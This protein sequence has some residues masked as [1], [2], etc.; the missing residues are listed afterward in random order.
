MAVPQDNGVVWDNGLA[1]YS[2]VVI[3]AATTNRHSPANG[4]SHKF[5]GFQF[6]DTAQG[7]AFR[8]GWIEIDLSVDNIGIFS[9]GPTVTIYGYAFDNTGSQPAM[10]QVPE[11]APMAVLVVGA[12]A[13][14][15]RGIR[16]WRRERKSAA[17]S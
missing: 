13:L 12:L 10:G 3:G 14:G 8:Y 5:L 1:V 7:N 17:I 15:A 16:A 2:S 4:Y 9:P 6:Q 11:P